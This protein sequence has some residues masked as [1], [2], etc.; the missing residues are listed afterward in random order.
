M[1]ELSAHAL[2]NTTC[3]RRTGNHMYVPLRFWVI[4]KNKLGGDR[5]FAF[6]FILMITLGAE[7]T[8]QCVFTGKTE[9]QYE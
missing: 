1:F 9:G 6:K 2:A 5:M 8:K 3:L 7:L 4:N